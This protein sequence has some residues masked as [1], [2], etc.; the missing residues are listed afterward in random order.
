MYFRAEDAATLQLLVSL[1]IFESSC[2]IFTIE[3]AN[4]F[5]FTIFSLLI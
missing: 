3:D 1:Q 4:V 2:S 5:C